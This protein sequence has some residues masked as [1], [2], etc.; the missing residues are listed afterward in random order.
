MY[1][2]GLGDSPRTIAGHLSGNPNRVQELLAANPHKPIVYIS[3]EPTF[4][5]L[6]VG[7]Q[8]A[9]PPS[10]GVGAIAKWKPTVAHDAGKVVY[11]FQSECPKGSHPQKMRRSEAS[12]SY[13]GPRMPDYVRQEDYVVVCKKGSGPVAKEKIERWKPTVSHDKRGNVIYEFQSKCPKGSHPQQMRRSQVAH[14]FWDSRMP[15]Y[16]KPDDL[17]IV[18]KGDSHS[19]SAFDMFVKV[20]TA[21]VTLPSK[22]VNAAFNAAGIPSPEQML[23]KIGVPTPDQIVHGHFGAITNPKELLDKIPGLQKLTKYIP[24][25]PDP[26]K[27]AAKLLTA[28]KDGDL[29]GIKNSALDIGHQVADVASMVPGIGNVIGGP[30]SSAITLL[31]TGSPLKAALSLLLGEI[32]G[33]PPQIRDILR[34]AF[35]SI[36]DVVEHQKS[37]TDVLLTEFKKGVEDQAKK[38]G[39][40][41]PVLNLVE[42]VINSA[43]Q[44]IFHHKPLDQAALDLAKTGLDE[45]R[46]K[47][48]DVPAVKEAEAELNELKDVYENVNSAHALTQG[49]KK[50]TEGALKSNPQIQQKLKELAGG[51]DVSKELVNL[52]KKEIAK[53]NPVDAKKL[54]DLKTAIEGLKVASHVQTGHIKRKRPPSLHAATPKHHPPKLTS[55]REKTDLEK[56]AALSPEEQKRL[57]DLA[58]LKALS[59]EEQKALAALSPTEKAQLA[60]LNPEQRKKVAQSAAAK[61]IAAAKAKAPAPTPPSPA[62]TPA[63]T[64]AQT[65]TP[66]VPAPGG[67]PQSSP[68]GG[69]RYPPYP[70]HAGVAGLSA[71]PHPHGHPHPHPHGPPHGR[72]PHGHPHGGGHHP[73]FRHPDR[74]VNPAFSDWGPWWGTPW[75]PEV[76]TTTEMCTRWGDP[77]EIPPAM[78]NA[79]KMALGASK[80]NP[81]TVRGPD[82]VLY[83]FSYE[84]EVL[85]ARP[86]AAAEQY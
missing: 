54:T 7:E 77:I 48:G 20:V 14:D 79:A 69:R 32:P 85:T 15:S 1:E 62:P 12:H 58:A 23:S 5:S 13:W 37:V 78:Q 83:L 70:P 67:A 2:V 33:I 46:K 31:E 3:G 49:V 38:Y 16:V 52:A 17:V 68:G 35:N 9:I 84:N 43:I 47:L 59:P 39:I 51:K 28:V 8:L 57:R 65:Q 75:S 72:H 45:A 11:V 18:C 27:T 42:G 53:A 10:F 26:T 74:F 25:M 36:A 19:Q 55:H 22:A 4:E 44:V 21:P 66:R 64:P 30:L 71:P 34:V 61:R 41:G 56:L 24:T 60:A 29:E 80:G 86:C 76:V 50:I 82:D 40:S 63:P 81:T 6:T 73:R